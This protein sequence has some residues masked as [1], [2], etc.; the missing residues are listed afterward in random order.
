VRRLVL[1]LVTTAGL[2]AA[3][4]PATWV[5]GAPDSANT[6][7]QSITGPSGYQF[8]V[9]SDWQQLP[10]S[11]Q[12]RIG[13]QTFAD[14][15]EVA[16]SDGVQHAHVETAAGFGIT[17]SNIHDALTSFLSGSSN[18]P[19]APSAS[20]VG[21]NAPGANGPT[22]TLLATPSPVQVQ[23]ADAAEAGAATYTD[24]NGNTRVVAARLAI[25]GTTSYLLL[26]DSTQDFYKTNPMVGQIES[27]FQL[28]SSASP[29]ANTAAAASSAASSNAP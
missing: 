29:V 23:N 17:T 21:S 18:A 15:G 22:L 14:D 4:M 25:H 9:P 20:A 12:E 28:S 10:L 2:L 19:G 11:L 5:A 16:S 27:S 26:I 1:S 13:S 7:L 24:P 8:Q 3:A 6:D